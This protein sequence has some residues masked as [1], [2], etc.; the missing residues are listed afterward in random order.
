M[1]Y[2]KNKQTRTEDGKSKDPNENALY[3][4]AIDNDLRKYLKAIGYKIQPDDYVLCYYNRDMGINVFAENRII[5][6]KNYSAG[7]DKFLISICKVKHIDV[8]LTELGIKTLAQYN[9]KSHPMHLPT[10]SQGLDK[11]QKKWNKQKDPE[12][13]ASDPIQ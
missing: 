9:K 12:L 10:I 11:A 8:D 13:I 5:V 7:Y 1:G 6:T 2:A 4:L 3:F